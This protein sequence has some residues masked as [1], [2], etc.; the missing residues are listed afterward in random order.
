MGLDKIN[1]PKDAALEEAT[2]SP[3]KQELI[4]LELSGQ[5]LF[6]GSGNGEIAQFEPRQSI[7]ANIGPD[8]EPAVFASNAA[9]YAIFMAVVAPLGRCSALTTDVN[10]AHSIRYAAKPETLAK[11]TE[12]SHGWV[13]VFDKEGFVSHRDATTEFKNLSHVTP[14]KKIRVSRRDLPKSI[15]IY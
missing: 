5:Y 10:G 13:Y 4:N 3:E 15:E 14:V 2:L 6:H 7:D 12:G 9:E 11:L 8:G 1:L